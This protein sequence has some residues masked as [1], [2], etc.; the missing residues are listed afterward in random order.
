MYHFS[1]KN[2]L[3]TLVSGFLLF[4]LTNCGK[5]CEPSAEPKLETRF[6]VA[7]PFKFKKIYAVGTSKIAFEAVPSKLLQQPPYNELEMVI[8]PINLN[9]KTTKYI[10]ESDT[11]T[12]SITI[13]YDLQTNYTSKCDFT[14]VLTNMRL[15][16]EK[17]SFKDVEVNYY[18]PSSGWNPFPSS[19]APSFRMYV[20]Y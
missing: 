7:T 13:A 14:F 15:V 2:T 12:D 18:P 20:Q 4:S 6:A 8:L 1:I 11:R 5:P 16:P 10:I 9:A 19:Y 17:S 3:K